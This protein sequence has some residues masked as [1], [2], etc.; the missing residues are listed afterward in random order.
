MI[1]SKSAVM[2]KMLIT[3]GVA[4][5]L[6]GQG[7]AQSSDADSFDAFVRAIHK[8]FEDFRQKCNEDYAA[9]LKDPW[10]AF[11]K[12][13]P[14]P[15]PKETPVPPV[16]CPEDDQQPAPQPQPMPY[17]EIIP[18]PQPTPQPRPV[19][20]IETEPMPEE[21][22]EI[23]FSLFGTRMQVHFDTSETL[24]LD[25]V[26]ENSIS[27]TWTELSENTNYSNLLSDCLQL[28]D[29]QELCDWP[30]LEMLNA[31]AGQIYGKG[32]N[33]ATLLAAYLYC[34]SGY[35]MRLARDESGK[36]YLLYA[37]RHHIYDVPYYTVDGEG[38]QTYKVDLKTL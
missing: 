11:E 5:C 9:F 38:G 3:L 23:S 17:D 25:G 8:D 10:K 27:R 14:V 37:S 12:K 4:L 1:S 16:V 24:R 28:R 30:Y 7:R 34:Q 21:T 33:E 20:P 26:D 29:R 6:C 32:S 35:K 2:K 22:P 18:V 31:V 19:E 36:L 15:T 13:K